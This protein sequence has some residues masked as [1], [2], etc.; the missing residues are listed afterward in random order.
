M[1]P[2]HPI[3][4]D[5]FA[6]RLEDLENA[7]RGEASDIAV[8]E[9]DDEAQQQKFDAAARVIE[10]IHRNR[11]AKAASAALDTDGGHVHAPTRASGDDIE[12]G[13][14]GW[15]SIHVDGKIPARIG[16]FQIREKL[17]QGG[18]GLVFLA[19]DPQLNRDVAL[20]IPQ[21]KALFNHSTRSRFIREAKA[22]A[23]L[24]HANIIPVFE[25][26]CVGPF[27]YITSAY[28]P[29]KPLG[30]WID[31]QVNPVAPLVAAQ[32]VSTLAEAVQHA[33]LRGIIHRDLKPDNILVEPTS[34]SELD[35][36]P[37]AT[38]AAAT[39]RITDFGLA[40][41]LKDPETLTHSGSVL[42]TPS[43]MSPEQ[44]NP[45]LGKTTHLVDIYG[46]GAV[47]YFILCQTPPIPGESLHEV[48]R[49]IQEQ[50]PISPRKIRPEIPRD[51]DAICLKCLEKN[52]Q[53]RYHSAS[54]LQSDLLRFRDGLPVKARRPSGLDRVLMWCRRR[55]AI[56]TLAAS[57]VMVLAISSIAFGVLLARS[58]SLK[59]LSDAHAAS[60]ETSALEAKTASR[61]AKAERDRTREA[62][63][64]MTSGVATHGL[65]SQAELTAEQKKFIEDTVSYFRQFAAGA[66]DNPGRSA[67]GCQ[68]RTPAIRIV[69]PAGPI[70]RGD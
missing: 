26:G 9:F 61:K 25:A 39:L 64:A 22:A 69:G 42:G 44:S 13:F 29:G 70:S 24:N 51:L 12:T 63:H 37:D 38:N 53:H 46:L 10:M 67:V 57:L 17:G 47:L 54:E 62:L 8:P 14:D 23:S 27:F 52:P 7:A 60:A 45:K 56:T 68:I 21:A 11:R 30:Q 58:N 41:D 34:L 6:E 43:F 2:S 20:K 59:K 33:H 28:C 40:K 32:W 65:G 19:H 18:Y 49:K 66:T 36:S 55:P 16:R 48:I 31:R 3:N 50:S 15:K 35:D 5:E 1:N 4:E